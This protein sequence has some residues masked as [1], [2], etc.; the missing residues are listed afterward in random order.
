MESQVKLSDANMGQL[1]RV[2]KGDLLRILGDIVE[3]GLFPTDPKR[4]PACISGELEFPL[5][6]ESCTPFAAK[7]RCFSPEERRMIREEIH[8]LLDRGVIRPSTSPWAA[9]CLCV[10]KK[11]GALRLCID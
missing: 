10:M 7:Q 9:Q 8:K 2:E 5:I 3:A 4:V 6:D 1:G 11:D